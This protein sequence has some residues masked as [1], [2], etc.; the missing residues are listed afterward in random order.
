MA[1]HD[2]L[3]DGRSNLDVYYVDNDPDPQY[4]EPFINLHER[5]ADDCADD[6]HLHVHVIPVEHVARHHL[7]HYP[8]VDDIE[9]AR[10]ICPAC[11]LGH[12]DWCD[13]P[14]CD[15]PHLLVALE[16]PTPRDR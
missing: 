4:D 9:H 15:R 11:D 5:C 7:D 10:D 8:G 13:D 3:D 14:T 1:D 6:E 2:H 12:D 16:R